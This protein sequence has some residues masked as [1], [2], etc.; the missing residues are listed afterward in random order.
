MTIM[1][2]RLLFS[3]LFFIVLLNSVSTLN[4]TMESPPEIEKDTEFQVEISADSNE[5]Y[6]VKIY[7]HEDTKAFSEI[8]DS[9]WK[10]PHNYIKEAFPER[11]KFLI[12]S[13]FFGETKICLKLRN[14]INQKEITQVCNPINVLEQSKN[15][16]ESSNTTDSQKDNEEIEENIGEYNSPAIPD[17]VNQ[18]ENK[19][20][21]NYPQSANNTKQTTKQAQTTISAY[22]EEKI[23]LNQGSTKSSEQKYFSGIQKSAI[24]V[25]L[26]FVINSTALIFVLIIKRA[27]ARSFKNT[28]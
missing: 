22:P 3:A 10:S 12:L 13:H 27:Y 18:Q 17:N 19:T 21:T 16:D 2:I 11:K 5:K 20:N 1:D 23:F 26:I 8:Y 7:V 25:F 24:L 28:V 14:S 6:D 15:D 9:E 4:I